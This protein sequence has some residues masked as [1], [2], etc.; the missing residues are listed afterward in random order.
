MLLQPSGLHSSFKVECQKVMF[1][2]LMTLHIQSNSVCAPLHPPCITLQSDCA[3]YEPP[4]ISLH[5][6]CLKFSMANLID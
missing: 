6:D 1:N 4:C 5:S 2:Q 3:I